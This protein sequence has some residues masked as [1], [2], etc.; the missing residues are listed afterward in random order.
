MLNGRRRAAWRLLASTPPQ[1]HHPNP[2]RALSQP[3]SVGYSQQCLLARGSVLKRAVETLLDPQAG[4]GRRQG[5]STAAHAPCAL[6]DL[7]C[8]MHKQCS[9]LIMLGCY[10][11][12]CATTKTSKSALRHDYH[13]QG[14][15]A[16]DAA[17]VRGEIT[18]EVPD[19]FVPG[20]RALAH[21]AP[22]AEVNAS[23][24][25]PFGAA[26]AAVAACPS[27]LIPRIPCDLQAC[28]RC[29]WRPGRRR[30]WWPQA[31]GTARGWRFLF[32][33]RVLVAGS[34]ACRK[35]SAELSVRL[36]SL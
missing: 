3:P 17:L 22:R 6:C 10:S 18:E 27:L 7:T 36:Q 25:R 21:G 9:H 4:A 11:V 35:L 29:W 28:W 24:M 13:V 19:E 23:E 20:K 15:K 30:L 32:G 33:A 8:S 12:C 5:G 34:R 2:R 16:Y 26:L 14:R 31:S 1:L